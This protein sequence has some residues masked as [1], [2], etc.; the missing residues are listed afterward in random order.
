MRIINYLEYS[1]SFCSWITKTEMLRLLTV[2]F[3]DM[4]PNLGASIA[5]GFNWKITTT[6]K[7]NNEHPKR[8]HACS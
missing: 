8:R 7:M 2:R 6:T 5:G 1:N 4:I 3:A